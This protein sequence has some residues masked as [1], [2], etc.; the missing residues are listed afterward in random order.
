MVGANVNRGVVAYRYGSSTTI[1]RKQTALFPGIQ[2]WI[3]YDD[4][5]GSKTTPVIAID[6]PVMDIVQ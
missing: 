3:V 1:V 2:K 4:R 5:R 6:I